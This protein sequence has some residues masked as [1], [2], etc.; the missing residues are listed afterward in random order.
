MSRAAHTLTNTTEEVWPALSHSPPF[1]ITKN[2][3]KAPHYQETENYGGGVDMLINRKSTPNRENS[4][5]VRRK[6]NPPVTK[7]T[8]VLGKQYIF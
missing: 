3:R 1:P 6:Q 8:A 4:H 7:I 5:N 2:R